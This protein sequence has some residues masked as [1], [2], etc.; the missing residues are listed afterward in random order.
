MKWT[1]G[2]TNVLWEY[3]NDQLIVSFVFAN[4]VRF[5]MFRPQGFNCFNLPRVYSKI[6]HYKHHLNFDLKN[7]LIIHEEI[8]KD[9]GS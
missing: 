4:E 5:G 6:S 1:N 2:C 3:L 8:T 9:F 7:S